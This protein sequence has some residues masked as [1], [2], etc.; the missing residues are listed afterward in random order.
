MG[1]AIIKCWGCGKLINKT[2][3]VYAP[4][5]RDGKKIV[6]MKCNQRWEFYDIALQTFL[7]PQIEELKKTQDTKIRHRIFIQGKFTKEKKIFDHRHDFVHK[8]KPKTAD[9]EPDVSKINEAISDLTPEDNMETDEN[10]K[11]DVDLSGL[12]ENDD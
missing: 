3:D 5:G 8:P 6:C 4:H 9:T 2:R 12:Q 1:D 7:Y 11:T 10:Q